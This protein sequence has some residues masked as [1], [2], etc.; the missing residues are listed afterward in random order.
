MRQMLATG[1]LPR[2][3]PVF[4]VQRNPGEEGMSWMEFVLAVTSALAWPVA[5]LVAALVLRREFRK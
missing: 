4:S 1:V 3:R 5:V 2:F